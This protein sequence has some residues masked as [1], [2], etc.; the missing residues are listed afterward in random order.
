MIPVWILSHA[1]IQFAWD[2]LHIRVL[3]CFA[4]ASRAE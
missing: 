4:W 3:F 1:G 2:M